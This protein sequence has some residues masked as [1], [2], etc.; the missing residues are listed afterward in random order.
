MRLAKVMMSLGLRIGMTDSGSRRIVSFFRSAAIAL[1]K[2]II[3]F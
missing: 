3:D 2:K 1:E